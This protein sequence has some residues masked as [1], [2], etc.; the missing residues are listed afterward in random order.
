MYLVKKLK[1]LSKSVLSFLVP[2]RNQIENI[3]LLLKSQNRIFYEI[4]K[5][6]KWGDNLSV[7]GP[8]SNL[9]Q[10][11]VVRGVLPPLIEEL[12]CQSILDVPCGDFFWMKLINLNINYIGGDIVTE[13]IEINQKQFGNDLR[14]FITIDITQD[15]LPKVDLVLCRD[16]LVH[17]SNYHAVSALKRIKCSGAKYL[18]TTTFLQ[19][20]QNK[21]ILTG[22]WRPISLQTPPFNFPPPLK[23]INEKCPV[24]DF[25]DKSL[26]LWKTSEIPDFNYPLLNY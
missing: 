6:N 10:T 11:E 23:L 17:F 20:K 25:R 16:C 2:R 15:D 12:N 14:N 9:D 8:G 4:Y 5:E 24:E 3:S 18:L 21:D 1:N 26:G 7:S 13:L 22:S 19:R